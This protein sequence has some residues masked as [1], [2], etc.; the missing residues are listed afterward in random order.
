MAAGRPCFLRFSNEGP[1]CLPTCPQA[2]PADVPPPSLS[3]QLRRA[4]PL[5]GSG[6][7]LDAYKC[8]CADA[9]AESQASGEAGDAPGAEAGPS[10]GPAP[11]PDSFSLQEA[12][13][14]VC[15]AQLGLPE[16]QKQLLVVKKGRPAPVR[17]GVAAPPHPLKHLADALVAG[18]S[19]AGA[20]AN[21]AYAQR[22]AASR[23]A[24]GALAFM[25]HP[26]S[27][28]LPAGLRDTALRLFSSAA[29]TL[30]GPALP[31]AGSGSGG[32][33]SGGQMDEAR[34]KRVAA[35]PA[36]TKLQGLTGLEPVKRAMYQL[37]AAV[38]R[39]EPLSMRTSASAGACWAHAVPEPSSTVPFLHS[40]SPFRVVRAC[41]AQVDLDKE[42]GRPLSRQL[43]VRFRWAARRS[44]PSSVP[45]PHGCLSN[46]SPED[47]WRTYVNR[48]TPCSTGPCPPSPRRRRRF[49]AAE[50]RARARPRWPACTRSC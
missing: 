32:G 16:P 18:A 27:A 33:G 8:L 36:L 46:R 28:Q 15:R 30:M 49:A 47:A 22:A 9:R 2:L 48:C 38:R 37:A 24:A 11:D 21:D 26:V 40:C 17:R 12:V 4:L 7:W 5:V 31:A 20:A 42:R 45:S 35:S 43:H 13:L 19:L 50:T 39:V 23:A 6:K 10:G 41:C 34:R 1:L 25:V 29:P 3:A 44:A 14:A